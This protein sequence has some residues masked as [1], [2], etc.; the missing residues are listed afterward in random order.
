MQKMGIQSV[1]PQPGTSNS[2]PDHKVYPYLLWG[3]LTIDRQDQVH[4]S[5]ITYIRMVGG[6]VYLTTVM[7]WHSRFVLS[8]KVSVGMETDFYVS[9]LERWLRLYGRPEIFNTDQDA[10]RTRYKDQH[11]W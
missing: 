9:A 3:W 8:W 10:Q 4:C 2:P 5:D 11:G 6:F 1:A 7:D